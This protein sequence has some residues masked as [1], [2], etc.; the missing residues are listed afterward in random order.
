MYT[1]IYC[2]RVRQLLYFQNVNCFY[3]VHSCKRITS[4]KNPFIDGD[5]INIDWFVFCLSVAFSYHDLVI[6]VRDRLVQ[7]PFQ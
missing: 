1:S 5:Q 2:L 6:F 4:I 7:I 3:I